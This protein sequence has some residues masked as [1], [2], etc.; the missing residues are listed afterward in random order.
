MNKI[1]I[2][3]SL[4]LAFLSLSAGVSAQDI[5]NNKFGIHLAT[6]D[7]GDI[8]KA[9]ELLNSSGGRW[10]YV[11]LVI[12][13]NDR[14]LNKWQ[15]VFD[16]LRE[17]RLIPIIRLATSPDGEN[18]RRPDKSEAQVW[19]DFLNKLHWVVENRYIILFNE[20]N[21]A[22]EWGGTVDA[23]NYAKV[24]KEFAS[25]LK[26]E[27]KDYFVMLAG[28]DASA[29]SQ[30]PRYEDEEVFLK[31]V[32]DIIGENNFNSLFHGLASHSY[33]NPG[34]VG[35]PY[36]KG[37]GTVG[38]YEWELSLL[39]SLGID[40]LPVF[41]TETGWNGDVLSRSQVAEN[42]RTAY[43]DTWLPDD[44]VIAVTPFILNYQA[45]PFLQFS[46]VKP[47]N[48]GVYP[49]FG[50]VKGMQKV[51]GAP[52]IE[53]SG[54]ISFDLPY[55]LVA[56]SSYHFQI[57]LKNTGQAIWSDDEDYSIKIKNMSES[58]YLISPISPIKPFESKIADV[59]IN[60]YDVGKNEVQFELYRGEKPVIKSSSWRFEVV[61][62]PSLEIKVGLLPKVVSTDEDFE[63]QIFDQYEQLVFRKSNIKI[64]NSKGMIDEVENI[65]LERPYRLV[66]LK[67]YYLPRQTYFNFKKDE[68]N[69]S[70]KAMLPVDFSGDGA[71]KWND[72]GALFTDLRRFDILLP[73]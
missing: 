15:G 69:A 17:R 26:K 32:I 47:E 63:L 64:K 35:S 54:K 53:Q 28:L 37:R 3:I 9:E 25:K 71:L 1:I 13:E 49:E 72:F 11:T 40:D 29:P 36:S 52:D 46:W 24:A 10:G 60:T 31:E 59:Y 48:I 22:T 14:D 41:I 8:Q 23:E 21:H 70:F 65:A 33:P 6:P 30:L 38:T 12:Q 67:K 51:R 7:D 55:E 20:P 19:V 2:V 62:L 34:F 56:K 45:E 44:R 61:P 42:F 16:K 73:W 5:K 4:V 68:N 43:Y 57:E 58:S 18:W 66:I 39:N 27:N 50:E